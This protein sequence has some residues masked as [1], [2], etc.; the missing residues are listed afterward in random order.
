MLSKCGSCG[1]FNMFDLK[2]VSPTGSRFKYCFVQCR[3][4]GVPVGVVNFFNDHDTIIQNQNEI[5]ELNRKFD[6]IEY[7]LRQIVNVLNSRR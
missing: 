7:T 2:E 4:C 1:G 3:L 6:S 5:K